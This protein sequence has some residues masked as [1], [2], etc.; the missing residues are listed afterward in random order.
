MLTEKVFPRQAEVIDVADC[1]HP[2]RRGRLHHLAQPTPNHHW[3]DLASIGVAVESYGL[4][5]L[6]TRRYPPIHLTRAGQSWP[7][8]LA[9]GGLLVALGL[10]L[11]GWSLI[12][13]LAPDGRLTAEWPG[14]VVG[15]GSIVAICVGYSWR[16]AK[17]RQRPTV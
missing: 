11:L 2:R 6:V 7:D 9:T 15:M 3:W 5:G 12:L 4:F 1:R 13:A 14:T 17:R 10:P 16:S 8:G